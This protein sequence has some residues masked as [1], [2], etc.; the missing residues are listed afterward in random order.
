[1]EWRYVF[2]SCTR[3]IRLNFLL[4]LTYKAPGIEER[5]A[6]EEARKAS[7]KAQ[8]PM[9]FDTLG[10]LRK[11]HLFLFVMIFSGF[12]FMFYSLFDVLPNYIDDWVNSHDI[13]AS[14]G[15]LVHRPDSGTPATTLQSAAGFVMVLD[16]KGEKIQAEGLMNVNAGMIMLTCFFFGYLSSR[17]RITTCI[18]FGTGLAT[19][20]LLIYGHSTTD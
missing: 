19:L 18:W 4:L 2:L 6:R 15:S 1:M 9:I 14:A 12:Y 10:E 5:L 20:A 8:R 11:P 3:I 16:K 7:G 13:V 17:V